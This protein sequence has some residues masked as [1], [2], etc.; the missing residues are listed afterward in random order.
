M[1][2]PILG[3]FEEL[4]T[5]SEPI[6]CLGTRRVPYEQGRKLGADG[7]REITITENFTLQRGHKEVAYK[8][9]PKKPLVVKTMVQMLNG[10]DF[11]ETDEV[12]EPYY[13]TVTR[14]V[15]GI[16]NFTY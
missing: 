16:P 12:P 15:Y 11:K 4:I 8:A 6:R 10:R 5:V 9:S 13:S 14:K 1:K 2:I 3:F 7:M